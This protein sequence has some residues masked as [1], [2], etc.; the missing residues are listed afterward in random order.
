[1]RTLIGLD[2]DGVFADGFYHHILNLESNFQIGK[3][4]G[5]DGGSIPY[6]VSGIHI[7]NVQVLLSCLTADCQFVLVSSWI[8][9]LYSRP[10]YEL[11]E[12]IFQQVASRSIPYFHGETKSGAGGVGR[13]FEFI[14]YVRENDLLNVETRLLAIDDSGERHFPYLAEHGRLVSPNSLNGFTPTDALKLIRMLGNY[15]DHYT[16][17][18]FDEFHSQK[19]VGAFKEYQL[20]YMNNVP[21]KFYG[22]L[23]QF[24]RKDY[25]C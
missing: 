15:S 25:G 4:F 24:K 13:E 17:D 18:W 6:G 9:Q 16:K 10:I 7:P 20:E 5:I 22:I 12:E 8:T 3:S 1:M 19:E 11:L 23:Q 14:Q 21:A 2:A